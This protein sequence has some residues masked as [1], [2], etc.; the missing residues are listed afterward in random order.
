MILYQGKTLDDKY[1]DELIGKVYSDCLK[2]LSSGASLDSAK[3]ISA[4]DKLYHR[5]MD[6]EFDEVVLPLLKMVDIPYATFVEMAKMFS[7]EGLEKKM[8]IELGENHLRLED[9]PSGTK[10]HYAPLGILFHIAAGNVDVL[11]AYSVIEGLLAGN[12]NIMKLPT[13]DSGMS[14]K[15]LSEL[16]AIEPSLKDYIYVFDV[17]STELESIKKLAN[18]ADGIV[19]WGGDEVIGAARN[20][21][22]VNS[23]II[24]WGHKLSFAYVGAGAKEEDLHELAHS[25]CTSNQLLCSSCQ[26]L[27]YHD[28]DSLE[29]FGKKFFEILREESNRLGGADLGMAGRNTILFY[30]ASLEEGYDDIV[31][32]QDGVSLIIKKDKELELSNMFRSVWLK[33]LPEEEI[34]ETLK[35][36]KSHLQSVALICDEENRSRLANLLSIA[37]VVRIARGNPSRMFLGEAHDG[38][39]ALREYTRIVE[40][41]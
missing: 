16:I 38:Q 37:G 40:I 13:G 8:E 12:I 10:R 32:N 20:I 5:V 19:V 30:A 11:P 27:Y 7:K 31:F 26:G 24:S 3:V 23:K 36:H 6:H 34:V 33:H 2:T 9:L 29:E 4:C 22:P 35:K 21:A 1:Q 41:D 18:V 25:I 39:Y 14:I 17:P 15:L 28:K